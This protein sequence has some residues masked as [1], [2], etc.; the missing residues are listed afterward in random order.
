MIRDY[1]GLLKSG[2]RAQMEKLQQNGHK[3]GFDDIDIPYAKERILEEWSEL[4]K[5]INEG[6]PLE[7]VRSEAAD[8]ANF[9]HMIIYVCDRKILEKQLSGVSSV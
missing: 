2:N 4:A 7:E 3:R 1:D 8:V 5:A 9:A 6:Q